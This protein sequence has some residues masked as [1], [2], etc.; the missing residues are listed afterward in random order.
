MYSYF[1]FIWNA[2]LQF[3]RADRPIGRLLFRLVSSYRGPEPTRAHCDG[4]QATRPPRE[5]GKRYV[6]GPK[7]ISVLVSSSCE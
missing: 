2:Q 3:V 5:G 1:F 4:I 7:T 6:D